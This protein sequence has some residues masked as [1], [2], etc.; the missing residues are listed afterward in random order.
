MTFLALL[1]ILPRFTLKR[2]IPHESGA[3]CESMIALLFPELV[4]DSTQSVVSIAL[5]YPTEIYKVNTSNDAASMACQLRLAVSCQWMHF[6][7]V[8][9]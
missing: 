7:L 9:K 2:E 1:L 5:V 4:L 8:P 3:T 6:K